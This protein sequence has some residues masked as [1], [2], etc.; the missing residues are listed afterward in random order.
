MS[1]RKIFLLKNE[2][3]LFLILIHRII[4]IEKSIY[5][6]NNNLFNL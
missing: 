3:Y 5:A 6:F 4:Q 1:V 2:I